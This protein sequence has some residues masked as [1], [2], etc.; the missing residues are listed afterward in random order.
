MQLAQSAKSRGDI[1]IRQQ[2]GLEIIDVSITDP[3]AQ[4]YVDAAAAASSTAAAARDEVKDTEYKTDVEARVCGFTA[5]TQEVFG[6]FGKGAWVLL[7][8]MAERAEQK[9]RDDCA[10]HIAALECGIM[11]WQLLGA[12]ERLA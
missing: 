4:S 10:Q 5:A 9:G 3:T 2:A 6:R 1:L 12:K 8:S 7:N 11:P